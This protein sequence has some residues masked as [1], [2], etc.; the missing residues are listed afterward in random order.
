MLT[1]V[2]RL[3]VM[4]KQAARARRSSSE[5]WAPPICGPWKDWLR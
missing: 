2:A 3:D 4:K 5:G 1:L